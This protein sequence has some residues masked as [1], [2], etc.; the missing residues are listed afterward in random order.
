MSL[1]LKT[2]EKILK[3]QE[4]HQNQ[5]SESINSLVVFELLSKNSQKFKLQPETFQHKSKTLS[6][7]FQYEIANQIKKI[8]EGS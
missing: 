7:V 6:R 1:N 4:S 5:V 8:N 2:I 3:F